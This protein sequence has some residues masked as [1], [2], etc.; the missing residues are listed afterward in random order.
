[1]SPRAAWRLE[2]LGFQRVYDYAPGKADWSAS[3]LPM[4]G[5]GTE[6]PTVGERAVKDALTCSPTEK[7]G[8]ARRRTEAAGWDRCVV[9]NEERV[10]LGLLGPKEL[11]QDPELSAE[12][13]MRIGPTTFRPDERLEKVSE[14]MR[15]RGV[16][17]VLVS[18]PD[19]RLVGI[20]RR[21]DA[22]AESG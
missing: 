15:E 18:T 9:L 8:E 2:A 7:V 10:V 6:L 20:L 13:V 21:A 11:A 12:E 19:G 4:Q 16:N 22:E 5:E 14:R 3:G 17:A 1:M